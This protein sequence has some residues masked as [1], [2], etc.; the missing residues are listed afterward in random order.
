[1][2]SIT[3]PI[4]DE[5]RMLR[6]AS[7]CFDRLNTGDVLYLRGSLGA[8]KTTFARGII[9]AAGYKEPIK[10]PTYSIIKSYPTQPTIHHL[11]VYR[12]HGDDDYFLSGL[13]D[14]D[15]SNS[16]WLIEWPDKVPNALPKP[17][18]EIRF[19][20]DNDTHTL[21]IPPQ[22]QKRLDLPSGHT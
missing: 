12:L 15:T 20:L 16:I 19:S 1:M 17:T 10:S 18:L 8:G 4:P 3:V 14:T 9:Q 2:T 22:T 21:T 11:D 7:H 5:N 6:I 13:G